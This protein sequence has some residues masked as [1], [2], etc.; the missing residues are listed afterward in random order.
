M[1]GVAGLPLRLRAAVTVPSCARERAHAARC[2]RPRRVRRRQARRE[3]R[4]RAVRR[5]DVA[6]ATARPRPRRGS[7]TRC[8]RPCS[9]APQRVAA[10]WPVGAGHG[11]PVRGAGRDRRPHR[12]RPLARSRRAR[13][14]QRAAERG[15]VLSDGPVL[16]LDRVRA[17]VARRL[18]RVDEAEELLRSAI[19]R[20]TTPR[21]APRSSGASISTCARLLSGPDRAVTTRSTGA[22]HPGSRA[23]FDELDMPAVRAAGRRAP[24]AALRRSSR[25]RRRPS[26]PRPR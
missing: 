11:R 23:L 15:M 12:C 3:R 18:G 6:A 7:T 1:A 25:R 21:P 2:V 10:R 26:G 5:G 24:E 4:R 9:H 22:R 16:L 20:A 13:R 14:S 17:I 19:S 8:A